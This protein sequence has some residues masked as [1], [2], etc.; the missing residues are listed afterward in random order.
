MPATLA[1]HILP[2]SNQ[3]MARGN[4]K[5]ELLNWPVDEFKS[6]PRH[7]RR[8]IMVTMRSVEE[9]EP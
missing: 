6:V 2:D 4:R 7:R 1:Y 9:N 8:T 5:R 3:L